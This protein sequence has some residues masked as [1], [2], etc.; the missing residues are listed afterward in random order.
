MSL[1]RSPGSRTDDGH[2]DRI[3]SSLIAVH[4]FDNGYVGK[5]NIVQ[6]SDSKESMKAWVGALAAAITEALLKMAF[7]TIQSISQL[8]S[9]FML[10]LWCPWSWGRASA[11]Q[12]WSPEFESRERVLTLGFFIGP[13]I[14][15][16]YWCSYQ[17]AESREISRSCWNLFLNRCKINMFKLKLCLLIFLRFSPRDVKSRHYEVNMPIKTSLFVL[18][19]SACLSGNSMY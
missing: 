16:E 5:Q 7:N 6:S 12:S 14:R 13:H 4:R 19:M 2:C 3:H 9:F 17:E 15:H 8:S 10:A 1:V 11:L 18:W